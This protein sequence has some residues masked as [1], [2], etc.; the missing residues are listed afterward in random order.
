MEAY[1]VVRVADID[2]VGRAVRVVRKRTHPVLLLGLA[3]GSAELGEQRRDGG[4]Q[5]VRVAVVHAL[6]LRLRGA[7]EHAEVHL[8]GHV[9]G[10][11]PVLHGGPARGDGRAAVPRQVDRE[12]GHLVGRGERAELEGADDAKVGARAADGPEQVR[13]DRLGRLDDGGVGEDHGGA[14]DPV[15]G[16]A[17]RVRAE[18]ETSVQGV[19]GDTDT[20][21][22]V[23]DHQRPEAGRRG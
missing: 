9:A 7:S 22:H 10:D 16:Q 3:E 1:H 21:C 20:V 15:D 2:G 17:V 5:A 19:T 8:L 6:Q 4:A 11:D 13:V 12:D 18:A 14:L 23:S